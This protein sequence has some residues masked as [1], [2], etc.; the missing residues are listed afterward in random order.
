MPS[1][2]MP[3][4]DQVN[5]AYNQYLGRSASQDEYQTYWANDPNYSQGIST[6]GE[7]AQYTQQHPATQQP[8]M[9]TFGSPSNT[10][11]IPNASAQP[12]NPPP[13]AYTPPGQSPYPTGGTPS[14]YPQGAPPPPPSQHGSGPAPTTPPP[15]QQPN[16]WPTPPA[17][18]A[19][20][21]YQP[22]SP[23]DP[24]MGGL[25]WIDA[26]LRLAQ[27]TDDP[28]YWRRVIA[29]DPKAMAGDPSAIAWWQDAIARGDGALAVRNGTLARRND[30]SPP[31]GGGG[32]TAGNTTQ[33]TDQSTNLLLNA[34]MQRLTQLQQPIQDPYGDLYAKQALSTVD[35]LNGDPYTQGDN[36]ALIASYR[37]PLTQARDAAKQQE[38]EAM[39]RRGI[40]PESGVFQHAMA[41]I[42]KQYQMGVASGTNQLAVK[43][44]TQKQANQAEQLQILDSLV[45]QG[46]MSR[47]EATARSQ[48]ILADAAMPL[49]IDQQRL[50]MLLQASGEGTANPSS[51]LTNIL[52]LGQLSNQTNALN[53][54]QG[55]ANA[56]TWMQLMGYFLNNLR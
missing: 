9:P 17:T 26:A 29:N 21:T 18:G 7:A 47:Q 1:V 27:S 53:N 30:S 41:Q 11:T 56:S 43:A 15:G 50:Q 10:I 3:S 48:E 34:I 35:K 4:Y 40:G 44:V 2:S 20:G 5:A 55:A 24:T 16:N 42:D 14:G 52:Q 38:A 19:P 36:A 54:Q 25:S 45:T 49:S 51:I 6:S 31:P 28:A 22:G 12:R 13:T 46:R 33:Y 39:A 37:D 23:N 8:R 32:N